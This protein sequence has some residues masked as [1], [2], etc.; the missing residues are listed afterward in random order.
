MNLEEM[1]KLL[2]LDNNEANRIES[3]MEK[4]ENPLPLSAMK[5]SCGQGLNMSTNVKS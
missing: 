3:Y 1:A 4:A 5:M 2:K